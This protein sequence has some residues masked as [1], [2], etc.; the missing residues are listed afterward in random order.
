MSERGA[1]M[2]TLIVPCAGGR[3]I[4]NVPIYIKRHPNGK[5]FLEEALE[6]IDV[7]CFDR[8]VIALLK[9]DTDEFGSKR[10]IENTFCD[11]I[12]NLVIIELEEE[13]GGPAETVYEAIKQG[14]V[15]G[16]I[17]IK[18]SICKTNIPKHEYG[19]FIVGI[20]LSRWD[21]DILNLRRK[22]YIILNEQNQILDIIEKQI[23]SE[24]I[25]VG[26]YG[27]SSAQDY[28]TAYDKLNDKNYPIKSLYVSHIIS[29]QI[30]VLG[31]I[32]HYVGALTFEDW[33]SEK[34]WLGIQ[35]KFATYFL[36]ID[37]LFFDENTVMNNDGKI[38]KLRVMAENGATLIGFTSHEGGN[39]SSVIADKLKKEC[40]NMQIIHGCSMSSI[41]KIIDS[42]D[43]IESCL[44]S[45]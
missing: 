4:G 38:E 16:Q 12:K 37:K 36:D 7:H 18:D 9:K 40:A 29:Y 32:F 5:L 17:V 14:N 23:R 22:S 42:Q 11:R 24:F 3:T 44:Y 35:R 25:S 31:K 28:I 45:L 43:D 13:T 41:K 26:M 19:N 2:K 39:E 33:S 8:V 15:T 6:G 21:T 20:N 30:G 10:I 1:C 27:F 34:N